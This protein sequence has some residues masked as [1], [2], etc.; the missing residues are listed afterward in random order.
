VQVSH[1][2]QWALLVHV[3]SWYMQIHPGHAL[4]EGR[5][6]ALLDSLVQVRRHC[7]SSSSSSAVVVQDLLGTLQIV[8]DRR[9]DICC[10][11]SSC[12]I[13]TAL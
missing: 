13:G 10:S 3:L 12:C 7:S 9:H 4:L 5:K 1:A 6:P 8:A 11:C 2:W